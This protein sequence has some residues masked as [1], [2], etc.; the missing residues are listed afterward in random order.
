ME[1]AAFLLV[2]VDDSTAD[3][4]LIHSLTGLLVDF[5]IDDLVLDILKLFIVIDIRVVSFLN[6]LVSLAVDLRVVVQD[7]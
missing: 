4:V 5:I 6:D 7:I 2:V 1:S 3:L